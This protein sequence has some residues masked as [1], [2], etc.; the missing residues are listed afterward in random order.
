MSANQNRTGPERVLVTSALP[1]ANNELHFGHIVGA[2]LPADVYV[3]FRRQRGDE[4]LFVCGT[5]EH[6]VAITLNAEKEGVG[7]QEFV[8]RWH[9]VQAE[10]LARLSIEFDIFSGTSAG[11]NPHHA[12]MSQH[13]FTRLDRNGY[14]LQKEEAQLFCA[15]CQRYLADRYVEGTC[16]QCGHPAARGDECPKC[17]VWIDVKKLIAP[18][19]K[20]CGSEP[21]LRLTTHWYLDLAKLKTEKIADWFAAKQPF[22][23]PNVASFVQGMLGDLRERPITRDLPWGVPVPREDA[24]GK[25]LY[26]WFDA[27]IGYVSICRSA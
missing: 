18:R 7:Y 6:G 15:T 26:V 21:T 14:I 19:C 8:D 20:T 2:Y 24:E 12:A 13:F 17:G 3:R 22:L 9:G 27:P 11:R 5:D 25:V 16:Y 10:A 1:Y 23:K 4:V